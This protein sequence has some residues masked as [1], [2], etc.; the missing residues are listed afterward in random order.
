MPFVQSYFTN[1]GTLRFSNYYL[2][3][4][5]EITVLRYKNGEATMF[6]VMGSKNYAFV[7]MVLNATSGS[8]NKIY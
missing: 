8:I 1:N 5:N 4:E 2:S 3:T 7:I 6:A